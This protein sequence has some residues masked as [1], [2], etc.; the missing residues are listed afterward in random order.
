VPDE[1]FE[2]AGFVADMNIMQESEFF[3]ALCRLFGNDPD[4]VIE[5]I[6]AEPDGPEWLREHGVG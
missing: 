5:E 4:E 3:R 1:E 6:R 2:M